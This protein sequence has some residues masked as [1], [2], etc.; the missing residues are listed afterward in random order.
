MRGWQVACRSSRAP[1][2]F[3]TCMSAMFTVNSPLRFKNSLVPSK[4]ST[5]QQYW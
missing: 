1:L 2:R 5:T 4:G 3:L